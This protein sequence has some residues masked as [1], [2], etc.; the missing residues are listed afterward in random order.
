MLFVLTLFT[1]L[2]QALTVAVDA[3]HGGIDTGATYGHVRESEVVLGVS[4]H[5][6]A[7]LNKD[8]EFKA[9][10]TRDANINVDLQERVRRA[11]NQNAELFVSLHANS[12]PDP[13]SQ[14][15]E[16]YFRNEL[17]P[18]QES[19][20]L[21]S[22]ENQMEEVSKEK[23][24]RQGDLSSIL[25]DLNRSMN[26]LKSYEMSWHVVKNWKVPFSRARHNAIKQGPFH[27]INSAAFPSILIE[28][29]F[30]TNTQEAKRLSSSDYQ[31]QIAQSIYLGLKDLK[32]TKDK[33]E[34]RALGGVH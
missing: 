30:V 33:K 20:R 31:K 6:T 15:M 25:Q 16:L 3:G 14:G 12:S 9:F 21:A 32:A 10:L 4:K 19:L 1:S 28:I 27:V 8:E 5:L 34:N 29:G 26:S 11:K 22:Q 13:H 23:Q 2:A 24:K 7:L 17:E 18:D